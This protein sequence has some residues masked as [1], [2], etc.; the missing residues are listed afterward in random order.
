PRLAVSYATYCESV[1]L[2][3]SKDDKLIVT[4]KAVTTGDVIGDKVIIKDGLKAGEQVV[5]TG[6][7]KLR[8]GMAVTIDNTLKPASK[9]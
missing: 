7:V 4:Q 1:F 5:L 2:I 3:T 6:H 9:K 8:Q